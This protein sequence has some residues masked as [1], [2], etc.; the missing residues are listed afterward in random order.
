MSALFVALAAL[1]LGAAQAPRAPPDDGWPAGVL[2]KERAELPFV[3]AALA[4]PVDQPPA[5][6]PLL[7]SWLEQPESWPKG[8]VSTL[9]AVG[10]RVRARA[11]ADGLVVVADGPAERQGEVVAAAL[12]LLSDAS[13]RARGLAAARAEALSERYAAADDGEARARAAL[14]R[15]WYGEGAA[16]ARA[17]PDERALLAAT[18][19][20]VRA[21]L[22]DVKRRSFGHALFLEGAVSPSELPLVVGKLRPAFAPAGPPSLPRPTP[23]L[24]SASPEARAPGAAG[25]LVDDRPAPPPAGA[26]DERVLVVGHPLPEGPW[27]GLLGHAFTRALERRLAPLGEARVDVEAG[28]HARLLVVTL[29]PTGA[30]GNDSGTAASVRAAAT[31]ALLEAREQ[32]ARD[33]ALAS[34]LEAAAAD[35]A[36]ADRRVGGWAERQA[37]A[38]LTGTGASTPAATPRD[39]LGA[40]VG[41]LRVSVLP[42]VLR[43][44]PL[45][46][47]ATTTTTSAATAPPAASARDPG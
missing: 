31:D 2:A 47:A 13:P 10:G 1:Q 35:L 32:A 28:R 23:A 26:S 45:P 33:R 4:I 3:V 38:H 41:L 24:A 25:A 46:P 29:R 14:W 30:L 36:R 34:D 11:F 27:G 8:P 19:A 20:D 9:F 17:G 12:A 18:E 15:A 43:A 37:R 16:A 40:L 21:A 6:L 22:D 5:L 42:E 39:Q 7:A 44:A